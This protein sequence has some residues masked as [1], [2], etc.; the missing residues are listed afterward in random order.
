MLTFEEAR[1][2][3]VPQIEKLT[4]GGPAVSVATHGWEDSTHYA[5][6]VE[7]TDGEVTVDDVQTLVDKR[8]GILERVS[9]LANRGRDWQEVGDWAQGDG[10]A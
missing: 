4:E 8:A 6:I 10:G 5:L 1:A 9:A 7:R 3:A 2:R